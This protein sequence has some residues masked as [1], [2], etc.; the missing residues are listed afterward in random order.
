MPASS[1][2]KPPAPEP[3]QPPPH[4]TP[5]RGFGKVLHDFFSEDDAGTMWDLIRAGAGGLIFTYIAGGIWTA[6]H[7]SIDFLAFGGGAGA[8]LGGAGTAIGIKHRMGADFV[9]DKPPAT[10]QPRGEE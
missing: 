3:P 8:L 5:T 10:A 2:P 7:G 1:D 9:K 6:F 4:A